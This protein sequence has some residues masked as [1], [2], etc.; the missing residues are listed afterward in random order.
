MHHKSPGK[1]NLKEHRALFCRQCVQGL[2]PHKGT[3][4]TR[5]KRREDT[6]LWHRT[7]ASRGWKRKLPSSPDLPEGQ[8]GILRGKQY[9]E[10][11]KSWLTSCSRTYSCA[12]SFLQSTCLSSFQAEMIMIHSPENSRKVIWALGLPRCLECSRIPGK[13]S[14]AMPH[15][16]SVWNL[17]YD[18]TRHSH[19]SEPRLTDYAAD[20]S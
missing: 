18:K 11:L 15:V 4:M 10:L 8:S 9:V 7:R 16:L 6:Y 17:L 5:A 12:L 20:S 2:T 1:C 13:L 3:D 14:L 19:K